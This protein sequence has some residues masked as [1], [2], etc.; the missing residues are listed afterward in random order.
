MTDKPVP[1]FTMD[2]VYSL[3]L[4]DLVKEIYDGPL[5]VTATD[6]MERDGDV[7]LSGAG[8]R[9]K[10]AVKRGL[11][12]EVWVERELRG[13]KGGTAVLRGYVPV[14]IYEDWLKE[15]DKSAEI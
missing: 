5:A 2:D 12:S 13:S 8:Q 4:P 15:R 9:C 6:V 10:Q 11:V 1:E 7:V 14:E 3:I